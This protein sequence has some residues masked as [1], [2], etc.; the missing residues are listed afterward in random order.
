MS[1]AAGRVIEHAVTTQ[2]ADGMACRVPDPSA[3]DMLRRGLGGVQRVSDAEVA[4]AMR[5]I[6][7]CTHQVAEGAGAAALAALMQQ[8]ARF[9][10]RRVAIVLSGGNVDRDVYADVLKGDLMP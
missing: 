6:F 1:L 9:A 3:L 5:T 2:L 4:A 8:R 7:E 10:G